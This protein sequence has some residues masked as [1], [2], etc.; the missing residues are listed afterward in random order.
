MLLSVCEPFSEVVA[1]CCGVNRGGSSEERAVCGPQTTLPLGRS[2]PKV[3]PAALS[4]LSAASES[5]GHG[6]RLP[7]KQPP[8][9]FTPCSCVLQTAPP[10]PCFAGQDHASFPKERPPGPQ[11]RDGERTGCFSA[12]PAARALSS[13][14]GTPS[15][16]PRSCQAASPPGESTPLTSLL[17][18]LFKTVSKVTNYRASRATGSSG[19]VSLQINCHV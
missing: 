18:S 10:S 16:P 12:R 19:A 8:L 9:T 7:A 15:P 17:Q 11:A 13:A 1:N 3:R 2:P 6:V 14:A 5:P 4:L